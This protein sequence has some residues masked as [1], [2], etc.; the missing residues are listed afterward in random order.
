M[1]LISKRFKKTR[2]LYIIVFLLFCLEYSYNFDDIIAF[3]FNVISGAYYTNLGIGE[4]RQSKL[5]GFNLGYDYTWSCTISIVQPSISNTRFVFEKQTRSIALYGD[6]R[7]TTGKQIVDNLT[8]EKRDGTMITLSDFIVYGISNTDISL[9]DSIGLGYKIEKAED[10]FIGLLSNK[11]N[12]YRSFGFT[13]IEFNE[14]TFFEGGIN[15]YIKEQYKIPLECE[16]NRHYSYWG[17]DI[18]HLKIGDIDYN[19]EYYAM[20]QTNQSQISAPEDFLN[21]LDKSFFNSLIQNNSC[22]VSIISGKKYYSCQCNEINKI[23]DIIIYFNDK[24]I[25]LTP[26]NLF[27][28]YD[29]NCRFIINGQEGNN[30]HFVLGT[31]LLMDY[32]SYFDHEKHTISLFSKNEFEK[33][34]FV[35]INSRRNNILLLF[36]II[37]TIIICGVFCFGL[38][39]IK[40]KQTSNVNIL[41]KL[42]L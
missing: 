29:M 36:L 32:V 37:L 11:V 24:G 26:K 16:V 40:I 33:L 39:Y 42:I 27:E 34:D 18:N 30:K 7:V 9:S 19:T 20:F 38:M 4:P 28:Q 41:L 1:L 22:S 5:F 8:I 13:S 3:K 17:C 23:P 21:K 31:Y 25:K 14:G 35:K 6:S 2:I 12:H 15:E 10:S